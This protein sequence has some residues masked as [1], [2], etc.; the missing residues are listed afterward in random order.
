VLAQFSAGQHGAESRVEAVMAALGRTAGVALT[1]FVAG[2]GIQR[3]SSVVGFAMPGAASLAN[4]ASR[5]ARALGSTSH[6]AATS[7]SLSWLPRVRPRRRAR[8]AS[9]NFPSGLRQQMS[10]SASFL[11]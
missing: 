6:A 1:L 10:R 7:P 4:T 11:Q 8:S 5:V 2:R 3:W 9:L